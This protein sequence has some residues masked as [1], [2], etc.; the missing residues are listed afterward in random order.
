MA[1]KILVH[2]AFIDAMDRKTEL[3]RP[4]QRFL[5]SLGGLSQMTICQRDGCTRHRY[6]AG[7]SRALYAGSSDPHI[8]GRDTRGYSKVFIVE[9]SA[10]WSQCQED[11]FR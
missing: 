8:L 6:R 5:G 4:M 1:R 10:N 11:D 9:T 3:Y 7:D 2:A